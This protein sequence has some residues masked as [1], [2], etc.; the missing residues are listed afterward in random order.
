MHSCDRSHLAAV[1]DADVATDVGQVPS[2][3]QLEVVGNAEQKTKQQSRAAIARGT[4]DN[5]LGRM[6]SNSCRTCPSG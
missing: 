5:T 1:N 4:H 6:Y 2:R 3:V